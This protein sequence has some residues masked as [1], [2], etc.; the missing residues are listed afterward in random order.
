MRD[1]VPSYEDELKIAYQEVL[2]QFGHKLGTLCTEE[3][4]W[5]YAKERVQ[6]WEEG[7]LAYA[8]LQKEG[9]P[10]GE[11]LRLWRLKR[12]AQKQ[13]PNDQ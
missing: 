13:P 8:I 9:R 2:Q 10:I 11:S 7:R 1:A 4:L 6:I 12:E 5:E 3:E